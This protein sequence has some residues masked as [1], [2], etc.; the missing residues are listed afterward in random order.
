MANEEI[1]ITGGDVLNMLIPT[2]GWVIYGDDFSSIRYDEGV[3]HITKKQFDEG[4]SAYDSWKA[5]KEAELQTRKTAILD[6][7]GITAEEASV[8]LS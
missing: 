7:L 1:I 8:L 3:T 2:G 6:R 4:F 5:L